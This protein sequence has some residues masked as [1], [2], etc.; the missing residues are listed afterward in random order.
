MCHS[1][2]DYWRVQPVFS[3]LSLG[4]TGIEADVHLKYLDDPDAQDQDLLVGHDRES[5]SAEKTLQTMY[6]DPLFKMLELRNP[7]ENHTTLGVFAKQPDV[8]IVLMID[9]KDNATATW[10][11]ILKQLEPFRERG[12]LRRYDLSH[13]E[14][15]PITFA[16]LIV[17][18]SGA[19]RL[20]SYGE[21]WYHDSRDAFLDA[22]LMEVWRHSGHWWGNR[23]D[24]PLV[25]Q[26]PYNL[27]NSYYAS[28]SFKEEIG[29]VVFGFNDKQMK[30]IQ[31]HILE[32]KRSGLL[33]R[34]YDIPEWPPVYRDFIWETL[35]REGVGM[36]NVDDIDRATRGPWKNDYLSRVAWMTALSTWIV[37]FALATACLRYRVIQRRKNPLYSRVYI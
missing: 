34:Y 9:V 12:F 28:T 1:H 2:N 14:D 20:N 24:N 29:S 19:T 4:C 36:L 30:Y 35:T 15:T 21:E 11:L 17:V 18:G 23:S 8:P 32:T 33:S 31:W 26:R 3:A 10:P 16:P 5:L 25:D 27:L 7:P 37:F 6:L 13:G 22:P